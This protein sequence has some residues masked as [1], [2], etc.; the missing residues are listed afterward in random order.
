[1]VKWRV[2]NKRNSSLF[3]FISYYMRFTYIYQL[4]IKKEEAS[5][6]RSAV[7]KCINLWWTLAATISYAANYLEII[8]Y[9]YV[10]VITRTFCVR[11]FEHIG[12]FLQFFKD[13]DNL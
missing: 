13:R 7:E 2:A 11:A 3:N 9:Y 6:G 4:I 5:A 12:A 10:N 1:M 8:L